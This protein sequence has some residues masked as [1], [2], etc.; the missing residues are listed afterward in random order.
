M[1]M[2][3]KDS[4]VESATVLAILSTIFLEEYISAIKYVKTADGME[5]WINIIPASIPDKLNNLINPNPTNGPIITLVNEKT[6]LSLKERI[7]NLDNAIPNDI[8][9]KKI[10]E[11]EIK[12]VAFSINF[13]DGILK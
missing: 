13:G 6:R 3:K 8:K 5:V 2:V 7:L 4:N 11:Y 12:K 9:T 1:G 10:V